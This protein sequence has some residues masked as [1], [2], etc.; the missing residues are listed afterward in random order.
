MNTATT[1]GFDWR[2]YFRDNEVLIIGI[3]CISVGGP[4]LISRLFWH[5]DPAIAP[6]VI[7]GALFWGITIFG[8]VSEDIDWDGWGRNA[9]RIWGV[10]TLLALAS[11]FVLIPGSDVVVNRTTGET[12]LTK[13]LFLTTPYSSDFIFLRELESNHIDTDI[14]TTD[15]VPLNCSVSEYGIQYDSRVPESFGHRV[16]S[17]IPTAGWHD[18]NAII[19]NVLRH[20]SQQALSQFTSSEIDAVSN[21]YIVP[22]Q[23]GISVTSLFTEYPLRWVDGQIYIDCRLS[24][25]S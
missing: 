12:S 14:T 18:F 23:I 15:G 22:Y 20:E 17:L 6:L 19:E 4:L 9:M 11:L 10:I 1:N 2:R 16:M 8:L 7:F 24:L 13:S 21:K 5:A 25:N 3:L